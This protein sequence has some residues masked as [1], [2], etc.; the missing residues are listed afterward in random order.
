ME[1]KV[2]RELVGGLTYENPYGTTPE[3]KGENK[4]GD[5]EK[6]K[7]IVKDLKVIIYKFIQYRKKKTTHNKM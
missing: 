3:E 6:F 4:V 1:G 2:F 7:A 5:F